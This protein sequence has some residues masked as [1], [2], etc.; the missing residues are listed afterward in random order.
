VEWA[1]KYRVR[2]SVTSGG[3]YIGVG[4]FTA[5]AVT[6]S[7]L[8]SGHRYFYLVTALNDSGES[9]AVEVSAIAK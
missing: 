1:T 5:L 6:D 7:R 8:K 3:P 9:A 2:R 4:K